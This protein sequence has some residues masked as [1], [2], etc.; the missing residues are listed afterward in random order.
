MDLAATRWCRNNINQRLLGIIKKSE[1]STNR[2]LKLSTKII[3]GN[4]S[5]IYKEFS[6]QM[7]EL[8]RTQIIHV[9]KKFLCD[10]AVKNPRMPI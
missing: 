7:S 3:V 8:Y 5:N 9:Q 6:L 2:V 10:T 4:F 1:A